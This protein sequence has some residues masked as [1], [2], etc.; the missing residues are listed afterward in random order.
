MPQRKI[1]AMNETQST[2]TLRRATSRRL[3]PFSFCAGCSVLFIFLTVI[4][5]SAKENQPSL[6][7][8]ADGI[9][10]VKTFLPNNSTPSSEVKGRFSFLYT[11]QIWEIQIHSQSGHGN[12]IDSIQLEKTILN[13]KKI[14]DGIRYYVTQKTAPSTLSNQGMVQA[15]AEPIPFPPPGQKALLLC[16]LS[17]CPNAEL[18][19]IDSTHGRRFL[20]VGLLKAEKNRGAYS[21]SYLSPQDIFLSKLSIFND[22]IEFISETETLQLDPPF[23]RGY[24][25]FEFLVTESAPFQQY[26]FPT[27]TVLHE[28]APGEDPKSRDDTYRTMIGTLEVSQVHVGGDAAAAHDIASLV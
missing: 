18:P 7:F 10:S 15:F 4:R 9:F 26:V 5:S 12:G 11:N 28:F 16:W 20:S 21:K 17:L 23:D 14:S 1:K 24:R 13:C 25:E 22:G 3:I 19:M 27:K 2:P 8:F 6:N